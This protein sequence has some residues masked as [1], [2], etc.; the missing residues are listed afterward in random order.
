MTYAG[1]GSRETPQN[2]LL[3]MTEIAKRLDSKYVLRSGGAEGA[4]KAFEAGAT[5]KQIFS[6]KD[7][8][9]NWAFETVAP[10]VIKQGWNTTLD[11]MKPFV[12]RLLAR[13][14]MIMLGASGDDPVQFVVCWTPNGK[15]VGG[16]AWALRLA[17][18]RNIPVYNLF[19]T[20]RRFLE[21][22]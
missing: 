9:P 20:D 12:Q 16:T 7:T 18:E 11:K 1:I 6:P 21:G 2:M 5:N 13:N 19:N 22:L 8:I 14:M 4:D 17:E 15:V 3:E 10:L